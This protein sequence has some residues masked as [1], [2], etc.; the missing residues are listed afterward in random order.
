MTL[1]E[2]YKAFLKTHNG[3]R[4]VP[5][6]FPIGAKQNSLLGTFFRVGSKDSLDLQEACDTYRKRLPFDL[7]P[8]GNDAGG[9]LICLGIHGERSGKFY[10]WDHHHEGQPYE[11]V[12]ELAPSFSAFLDTFTERPG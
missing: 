7:M 9:S 5:D 11:N 8:I 2:D 1:P 6:A 4:P 12:T 10:F 3:G